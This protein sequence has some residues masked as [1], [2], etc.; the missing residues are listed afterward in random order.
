[1]SKLSYN[2]YLR[3]VTLLNCFFYISLNAPNINI[4][5]T[6]VSRIIGILYLS[7]VSKS[8]I[9]ESEEQLVNNGL[10]LLW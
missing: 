9:R 10:L 2:F 7:Q 3:N 8:K 6:F 5:N 1:M 4:S